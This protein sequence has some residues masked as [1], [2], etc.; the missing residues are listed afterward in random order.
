M[1]FEPAVKFPVDGEVILGKGLVN[2]ALITGEFLALEKR[3]ETS[4]FA[5]TVVQ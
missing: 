4:V 1:P 3:K 2:Q 5:G